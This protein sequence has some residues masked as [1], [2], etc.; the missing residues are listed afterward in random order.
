MFATK[1]NLTCI[2]RQV[3]VRHWQMHATE[4]L[5]GWALD[6]QS[7]MYQLMIDVSPDNN[8]RGLTNKQQLLVTM[9]EVSD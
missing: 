2:K 1:E 8:T 3:C 6:V 7:K 9:P 5:Q 4:M